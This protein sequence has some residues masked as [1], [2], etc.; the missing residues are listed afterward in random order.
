MDDDM[1][2]LAV[3]GEVLFDCFPTGENVLGGAPFNVA[4]HLQA[5]G[6]QPV[7]ISRVGEDALGDDII[8]AMQGWGF[9]MDALQR[10]G[11]HPSGRVDV[12]LVDGEPEYSITPDCAYDF[13]DAVHLPKLAPPTLLYHGSLA[14]RNPVSRAALQAL[15]AQPDVDAFMDVNLRSPW[16]HH[17]DVIA[18]LKK[19]RWAKLNEDE[20]ALLAGTGVAPAQ[21]QQEM[22]LELLVVTMGEKGAL[23]LDARGREYRVMP[24]PNDTVVDV[25]GAGDAFTSVL[26]HGLLHQQ[27]LAQTLERAQQFASAV[28][29]LRGA[30]TDKLSFYVPFS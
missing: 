22:G 2:Q 20:L 23:A 9:A 7:F 1:M 24:A 25:V 6:D 10:D 29:G 5:F 18:S 19:A 11:R 12:S 8:A 27:P 4:W 15:L 16:W 13:I 28:V 26:L 17:E 14:M 21:F 3:F 30:T